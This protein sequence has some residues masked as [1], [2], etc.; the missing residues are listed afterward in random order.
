MTQT[1]CFGGTIPGHAANSAVTRA[2]VTIMSTI[3]RLQTKYEV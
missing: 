2:L 1:S 3:F